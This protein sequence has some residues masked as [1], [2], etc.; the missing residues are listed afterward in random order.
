MEVDIRRD[1]HCERCGVQNFTWVC[2]NRDND[3]E[4]FYFDWQGQY[5][6]SIGELIL[7]GVPDSIL[8]ARPVKTVLFRYDG[9]TRCHHCDR[10]MS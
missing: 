7:H 1:A 10:V 6:N 5:T 2:R 4:W 3:L 9:A 8:Y